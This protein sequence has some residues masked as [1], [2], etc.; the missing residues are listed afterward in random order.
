MPAKGLAKLIEECGE[1]Q[2]IAGKKL[3]YYTT[4]EHPDGQGPLSTRLED[5]IA[6]GRAGRSARARRSPVGV[7]MSCGNAMPSSG[8]HPTMRWSPCSRDKGHVGPCAHRLDAWAPSGIDVDAL[9]RS[10]TEVEILCDAEE[11]RQLAERTRDE[12][13]RR[14]RAVLDARWTWWRDR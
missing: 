13:Q 6:D 9:H 12:A 4:D 2:Q 14:E 1:L 8:T 3:A 11:L 7:A 5:E 10:A